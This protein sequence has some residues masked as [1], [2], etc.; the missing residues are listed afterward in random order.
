MDSDILAMATDLLA[1]AS[2]YCLTTEQRL[3]LPSS[4]EILKREQGYSRQVEDSA[5]RSQIHN[6]CVLWE[7]NVDLHKKKTEK[8]CVCEREKKRCLMVL[9]LL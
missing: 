8:M 3:V 6:G 2:G 5:F 4:L 1:T 7:R 9:R